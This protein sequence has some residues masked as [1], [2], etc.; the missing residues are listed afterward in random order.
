MS[1]AGMV[2]SNNMVTTLSQFEG[3]SVVQRQRMVYKAIWDEL[4]GPLHAVD[5]IV[6]KTPKE[7]GI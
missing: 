3:K 7:A 4:N 2:Q 6:A 5:S 1:M